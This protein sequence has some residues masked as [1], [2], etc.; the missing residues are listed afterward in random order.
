M[1]LNELH[2]LKSVI[3]GNLAVYLNELHEAPGVSKGRLRFERQ[4]EANMIVLYEVQPHVWNWFGRYF[5]FG[6]APVHR[7]SFAGPLMGL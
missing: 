3:T 7:R 2:H 4:R 5:E 6:E 1:N